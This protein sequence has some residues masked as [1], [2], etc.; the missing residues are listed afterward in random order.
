MPQL[1]ELS[2]V[3]GRLGAFGGKLALLIVAIGLLVIGI[4]WNG[5]AGRGSQIEVTL[6]DGT[7]THITDSRAQFP[8]LLSGGFLGL[9]LIVVGSALL[10]SHSH[11]ADRARLEAK[12]D[13]LV[14]AVSMP[15]RR[16]VAPSDVSGLV[17]AGSTSYHRPD[18]RLVDGRDETQLLTPAEAAERGLSACRICAPDAV[19]IQPR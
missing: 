9:G 5:A 12:L 19:E 13:E 16:A 8:W 15:A 1:P 7:K 10:V 17:A 4:G 2:R 3:S 11:R 6:S 18:C 14:D